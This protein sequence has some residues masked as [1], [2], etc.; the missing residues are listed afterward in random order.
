MGVRGGKQLN[1]RSLRYGVGG[2]SSCAL[3]FIIRDHMM[4]QY[5]RPDSWM[6][7]HALSHVLEAVGWIFL[8]MMFRDGLAPEIKTM[9]ETE[10]QSKKYSKIMWSFKPANEDIKSIYF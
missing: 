1:W 5:C 6:Q 4:M 8:F 9:F 3:G 10:N 7:F 2:L